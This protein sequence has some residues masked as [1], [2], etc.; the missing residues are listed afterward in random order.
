MVNTTKF[1]SLIKLSFGNKCLR[2]MMREKVVYNVHWKKEFKWKWYQKGKENVNIFG[3]KS[4]LV[5][6][7]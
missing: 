7:I 2:A 3:E 6:T 4:H 1:L 5:R